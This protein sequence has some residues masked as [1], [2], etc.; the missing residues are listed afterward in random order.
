MYWPVLKKNIRISL[1]NF[2]DWGR[3][4]REKRLKIYDEGGEGLKR[5]R[6]AVTKTPLLKN[7]VI[8]SLVFTQTYSTISHPLDSMHAF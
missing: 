5:R 6:S 1:W 2:Q 4:E 7:A 3:G 8:Q